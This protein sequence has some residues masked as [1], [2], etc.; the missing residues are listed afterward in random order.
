MTLSLLHTYQS[1][2]EAHAQ[3]HPDDYY[4]TVLGDAEEDEFVDEPDLSQEDITAAE[5]HVMAGEL[6]NRS[7]ETEDIE[8]LGN[9]VIDVN[10]NWLSHHAGKLDEF[11]EHLFDYWKS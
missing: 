8:L 6:P 3:L 1:C 10:F 4:G 7:L 9:R 5:W 2:A 11:C